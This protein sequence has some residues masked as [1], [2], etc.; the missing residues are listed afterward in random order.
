MSLWAAA[1]G[2]HDFWRAPG[3][4]DPEGGDALC[5]FVLHDVGIGT[6]LRQEIPTT[7]HVRLVCIHLQSLPSLVALFTL[8]AITR[9]ILAL[10]RPTVNEKRSADPQ[11]NAGECMKGCGWSDEQAGWRRSGERR[12]RFATMV[13]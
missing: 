11:K 8:T 6:R 9:V 7:P 13:S 1:C 4:D 5:A 3:S 12:G 2:D 10:T